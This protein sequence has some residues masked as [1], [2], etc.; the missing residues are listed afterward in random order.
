MGL[1]RLIA[2][3]LPGGGRS[4]EE[5]ARRLDIPV[6]P[7]KAVQPRYREFTVPR[8]SGPPRTICAPQDELKALQKHI[9]IRLLKRLPVH[10]AAHGFVHGRS[11]VTN[12]LPHRRRDVVI[13]LDIKEYFARTREKRVR[14]Y[15]RHI[16]WDAQATDLL[17]RLTTYQGGL[18]PGAPTSPCLSNVLNVQ[19]DARLDGLARRF[20]ARYT[21]YADD[22]TFSLGRDDV[23]AVRALVR[24]TG[25]IVADYGYC[26]HDKRKRRI[27]HRYQQQRVTGL[28]VNEKVQLPRELR[29]RL[30]AVEHH[31]DAGRPASMTRQELEGWRAIQAMID[32]Q[33][34]R[35]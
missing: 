26:L 25:T 12:A 31:L 6:G 34:G 15:F 7:L 5:L 20:N 14:N 21:R 24:T 11:I 28:V 2:R 16:G 8:H 33:T 27:A 9:Y 17:V 1:F 35:A 3:L 4:V 23:E 18:P 30:R 13:G 19:M 22:I 32:H 10:D 29:R